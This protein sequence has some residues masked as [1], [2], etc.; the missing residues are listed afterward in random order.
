MHDY[1]Y[2]LINLLLISMNFNIFKLS[3]NEPLET[4]GIDTLI[5][6][7][8]IVLIFFYIQSR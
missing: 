2:K 4:G 5:N 6:Q 3:L 7:S 8:L 1:F